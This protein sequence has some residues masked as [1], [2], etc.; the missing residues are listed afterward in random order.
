MAG[1]LKPDESRCGVWVVDI[2]RGQIVALL[3]FAGNIREVFAVA[4]LPG[5]RYPRLTGDDAAL[6]DDS[7]VLPEEALRQVPETLR[8]SSTRRG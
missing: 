8:S 7:F 5:I 1:G 4:L 2:G 3:E 6:I